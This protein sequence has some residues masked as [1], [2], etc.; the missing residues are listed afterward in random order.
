[1][2]VEALV[3]WR[4]PRQ[5]LIPPDRFIPLA[6]QT[7][8][9]APLTDW[10]LEVALRQSQ[11]WAG[12]GLDLGVAVNLSMWNLHDAGL[13]RRWPACSGATTRPL[14]ACAWS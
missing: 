8:L 4:H 3:R 6:E 10:V 13:R 12:D 7:G 1:V 5:G 11:A 9:I 2:G 14:G